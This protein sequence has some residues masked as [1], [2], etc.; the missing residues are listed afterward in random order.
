MCSKIDEQGIISV[1]D[2]KFNQHSS[3]QLD[4]QLSLLYGTQS[5]SLKVVVQ[6]IQQQRGVSDCGV[7]A[8]SVCIALAN[9]VDPCEL[10]WRQANMRNHLRKCIESERLST[11]PTVP[12]RLG[13]KIQ[14]NLKHEYVIKLWCLCRLPEFAFR[15]MIM[16]PECKQWFHKPCVGLEDVTQ[17]VLLFTCK[18]CKNKRQVIPKDN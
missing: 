18:E 5:K 16:C 11:P 14:T 1:Y 3:E 2:S 4:I 15:N 7:F 8:I 9:D 17:K 13:K 6:P 10:R 12:S